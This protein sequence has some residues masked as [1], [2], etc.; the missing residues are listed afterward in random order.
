MASLLHPARRTVHHAEALTW[1]ATHPAARGTSIVT[2]LPDVSEVPGLGFDGWRSWFIDA[3]RHVIRWLPEDGVAVFFQSDIRRE[4]TWIDKGY[5]VQRAGE[6][7]GAS[8]LW[9][10][11]V[12]RK[13]P[14]TI[15]VGRASYSH[16][17][18]F[19]PQPRPTPQRPGPD[20]L[21]DAGFMPWNRAMGET[22]CR[23][24]CRFLKEETATRLVVDPFCGQGSVLAVANAFGFEAVGVDLSTRRC[25]AARKQTLS[26]AEA[27]RSG[28]S[29]MIVGDPA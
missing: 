16:M 28:R 12:C 19:A 17:L 20:V 24:A 10:K 14:G 25:R 1:L 4:G 9:H 8:L 29:N 3:A 7:V 11:I 21:G 18:C 6:D 13:P 5:L 26:G 23:V 22:A 2:S 15:A 27:Q